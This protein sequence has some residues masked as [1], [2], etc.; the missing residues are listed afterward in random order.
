LTSDTRLA[1]ALPFSIGGSFAFRLEHGSS[2][3]E[4]SWPGL[5]GFCIHLYD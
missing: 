5:C 1:A 3:G 2:Y 4:H